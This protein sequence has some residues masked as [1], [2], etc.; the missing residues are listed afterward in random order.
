MLLL[1]L[2]RRRGR[3]RSSRR[4]MQQQGGQKASSRSKQRWVISRWLVGHI[5]VDAG[6][7]AHVCVDMRVTKAGVAS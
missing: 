2:Q 7:E 3:K 5:C 1:L 4:A 6:G